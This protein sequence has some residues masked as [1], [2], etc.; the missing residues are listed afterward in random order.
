MGRIGSVPGWLFA[1]AALAVLI[2]MRFVC[3]TL[4]RQPYICKYHIIRPFVCFAGR[5]SRPII[6]C[7]V[8][9]DS[10]LAILVAT[11]NLPI[12]RI[13][14]GC[15]VKVFVA[16]TYQDLLAY[17][18]AVTRS[19]MMAGNL[20]EDM[21]YWPADDAPPLNVS[22]RHLRSADL[23]VLLIA[24]RY[25]T[26]PNGYDS[27]IT[28]LEFDEAV[29]IKLPILAFRVDPDYPWPPRFI[30]NEPNSRERL[31]K[32]VKKIN[33]QVT[34]GLFSTPESLEVAITHALANFVG[35]RRPVALPRYAQAR[36]TQVSRAESLY[37]SPDSVVK[38]GTA[39]DGAPLLLS[40]RRDISVFE[41]MTTI[42]HSLGK[43]PGDPVFDDIIS[44]LSQEA[45]T[46]AATRGLFRADSG[47]RT[48]EVYVTHE[49]MVSLMAPNLFQSMLGMSSAHE[50][51]QT[52]RPSGTA[53]THIS[54]LD[55]SDIKPGS[56]TSL[57]GQNR[58]LCVALESDQAVWS[59][60]WTYSLPKSL[61]LSR[62]F[63]E[64][65]LERL[66][67]VRYVISERTGYGT[68][69]LFETGQAQQYIEKWAHYL[70]SADDE[71][72]SKLSHEIIIPRPSILRLILDVMEE[73]AELHDSGQIHGDIKPSN[74]LVS[75]NG[76]LLIDEVG[77][78]VGEVSPTISVG[79]SPSE[80]LL[81]Q[82]LSC[83][84][85]V[86]PLG[87]LLLHVLNGE[88]L[89][90]EVPFRMP[91]GSKAILIDDPTIFIGDDR[92]VPAA[93][94]K[95][96]CRFI[97]KALKSDPHKRWPNA[98]IMSEELRELLD[99]RDVKGNVSLTLPWGS[100]PSLVYDEKGDMT[101]GWI[102]HSH[103]LT[104]PW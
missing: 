66:S 14:V 7:D 83:S 30:E 86:Y 73:V 10:C 24:H 49:T 33:S 67:G 21:L 39:P 63:I 71:E 47:G 22:R 56:I 98:R 88:P 40:V 96:W 62:P 75:R 81:R 27:S 70:K 44:K 59:G 18:A 77:L 8:L 20:S 79:W 103:L 60:G 25:G 57:G 3:L 82:P 4:G 42:A 9:S 51:N 61:A 41:A 69:R 64:E 12:I 102:M 19:I 99:R 31:E 84:A 93:T 94:R 1:P 95:D 26:P 89:G 13:R 91:G 23:M 52:G 78:A 35:Q 85:D 48:V 76:A 45:R 92:Y 80:Q 15:L 36:L 53:E 2:T 104:R 32:F 34:S 38:V 46:F 6:A 29:E 50:A 28:E 16:S 37:Y 90:K 74:T 72:L 5:R 65:G 101:M 54:G 55:P 43:K 58:F 100:Q 97:E 87:Q 68:E 17:R 11:A